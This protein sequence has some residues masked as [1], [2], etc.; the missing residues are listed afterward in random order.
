MNFVLALDVQKSNV[1]QVLSDVKT[2]T[3]HIARLP[4]KKDLES[5]KNS[6]LNSVQSL[7]PDNT[8]INALR[9][10]LTASNRNLAGS[11]NNVTQNI[12]ML[13]KTF[14]NS[15]EK[16][17]KEI[18]NLSRVERVIMQTADNVLD[19]KRRAEYGVHQI[20]SEMEKLMKS[21]SKD[22]QSAIDERFDTFEMS[23]L[24]EETGALAN[25]TSKIGNEIDQVWRQ[26]GIMHQQM[27]A[28]TDTLNKLQT[29]T[30]AYVNGSLNVM[31]NVK[32]KVSINCNNNSMY[33][34]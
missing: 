32:G 17:G 20:M 3:T 12:G 22:I 14:A 24:D 21:S 31:D 18:E 13:G 8:A 1:E 30:D 15:S 11:I 25:L 28:S 29:Q 26:I 33:E 10:E 2:L 7:R 4:S 9:E 6:T 16:I 19:A 5:L 34:H 23:V 27:S